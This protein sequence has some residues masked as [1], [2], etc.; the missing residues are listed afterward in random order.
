MCLEE[1]T[2]KA[3]KLIAFFITGTKII[4]NTIVENKK[5]ALILKPT[6]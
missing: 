2:K 4:Y 6:N 5:P 3:V 1:Y